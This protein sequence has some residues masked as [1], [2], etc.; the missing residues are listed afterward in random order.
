MVRLLRASPV[1]AATLATARRSEVGA[2]PTRFPGGPVRARAPMDSTTFQTVY[3]AP[4]PFATVLV[5]VS[6]DDTG[7]RTHD[8]RVRAG[9]RGARQPGCR[10]RPSSGPSPSTRR[11]RAPALSGVPVSWSRT[12]RACSTTRSPSPRVDRI[13]AT[14]GPLPDLA[15]WIEH[16]DGRV[17]F[18]LALVD[19][20]GGDVAVDALRRRRNRSTSAASSGE[21]Q[22]VQKVPAGGWSA[23]RYQHVTENVLGAATPRW[24]P[25]RSP[26]GS[27]QGHRLVLLAGD[28]HSK[29]L[30]REALGD[31]PDGPCVE[32]E[33]GSRAED[34]GGE[35]MQQA[36]ARGADAHERCVGPAPGTWCTS[37]ASGW[38]AAS[39][40]A[41][42]VRDVADAFVRGQVETLLVDPAL[43]G[44]PRA[45][46]RRAPRLWCSSLVPRRAAGARRPRARGGRLA[47]R[48][49][50][51]GAPPADHGR[52][53]G[54]RAAA[55]EPAGGRLSAHGHARCL[56]ASRRESPESLPSRR[57]TSASTQSGSCA[58]MLAQ[59]PPDRLAQPERGVVHVALDRVPQQLE[60]GVLAAT[61]LAQHRGAP[62]P[63]G[64]RRSPRPTAPASPVDGP[65]RVRAPARCGRDVVDVVPPVPRSARGGAP[66]AAPRRRARVGRSGA[67]PARGR[68]TAPPGG[69]AS[70]PQRTDAWPP[71][72]AASW[73]GRPPAAASAAP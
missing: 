67:W 56:S 3:A 51:L 33:S 72:P 71:T 27:A 57:S 59:R 1:I 25:R 46:P 69:S 6:H 38:A 43:A 35:A 9:L 17:T 64:P 4:G 14:W 30:V 48:R 44:R 65:P 28:P 42:G 54:H 20:E 2:R 62:H 26:R 18:V 19:H 7:E 22:Y 36:V 34:G 52:R 70:S 49:E 8:L 61:E 50:R 58:G 13:V 47:H 24:W 5:D 39:S 32:L 31:L 16:V 29:A 55:L 12:P 53:P 10:P 73:A 45:R 23:M 68:R 40:V 41:T 63:D 60:V 37:C 66:A 15:H 21:T 11:A